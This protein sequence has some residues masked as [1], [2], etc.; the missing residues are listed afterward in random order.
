MLHGINR[1]SH[2]GHSFHISDREQ[3]LIQASELSEVLKL[4]KSFTQANNTRI[5]SWPR[6]AKIHDCCL[7]NVFLAR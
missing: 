3:Y 6:K 2:F 7:E 1:Y 4:P 5:F